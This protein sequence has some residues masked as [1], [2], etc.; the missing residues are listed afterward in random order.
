MQMGWIL[1]NGPFWYHF[2][3][4]LLSINVTQYFSHRIYRFTV[5]FCR[6]VRN[7]Y[8]KLLYYYKTLKPTSDILYFVT[9]DKHKAYYCW[10][11]LPQL[12][13]RFNEWNDRYPSSTQMRKRKDRPLH[14]VH[15]PVC[16]AT[17][18][19]NLVCFHG[20]TGDDSLRLVAPTT[21]CYPLFDVYSRSN[22]VSNYG[23]RARVAEFSYL[24]RNLG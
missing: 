20:D 11:R 23:C 24:S 10:P 21:K 7:Q 17:G 8:D 12:D 6:R 22:V 4:Q 13:D 14:R 19:F 18:D 5:E 2:L 15:W 16:R 3:I 1:S 9:I